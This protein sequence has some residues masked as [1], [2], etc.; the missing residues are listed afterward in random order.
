MLI[1]ALLARRWVIARD[2]GL[3]AAIAAVISGLLVCARR[4]GG[5]SPG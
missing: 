5:R 3:S 2:V 4:Q 1:A